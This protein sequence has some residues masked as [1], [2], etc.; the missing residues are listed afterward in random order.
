MQGPI[1]G[2]LVFSRGPLP[3]EEKK[4]CRQFVGGE[5]DGTKTCSVRFERMDQSGIA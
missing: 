4:M 1:K 3:E 2:K 5:N